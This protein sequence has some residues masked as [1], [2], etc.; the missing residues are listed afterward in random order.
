[1]SDE[2]LKVACPTCDT[3]LFFPKS[4]A[5]KKVNCSSCESQLTVPL[6][7]GDYILQQ[8]KA[9]DEFSETY[10]AVNKL[11]EGRLCRLRVFNDLVT[12]DESLLTQLKEK[13]KTL[14]DL[15]LSSLV[16]IYGY[17]QHQGKF[18]I[19]SA[20]LGKSLKGRMNREK[21][22]RVQSYNYSLKIAESLSELFT[23]NLTHGNLKSSTINLD[24][25]SNLWL[26]D[27]A[28]SWFVASEV[29][30][31]QEGLNPINNMFYAAPELILNRE[32]TQESDIYALGVLF[33]EIFTKQK[34]FNGT[35][36]EVL[37]D[38]KN[39]QPKSMMEKASSIPVELDRLVL[40]MLD[41]AAEK[42]PSIDQVIAEI[43]NCRDNVE[44]EQGETILN[45]FSPKGDET[46]VT[47][48]S[49]ELKMDLLHST[50]D[51]HLGNTSD[52]VHEAR[53][54][55]AGELVVED[56]RESSPINIRKFIVVFLVLV[57]L[58]LSI[59]IILRLK[60][61]N[62]D[63]SSQRKVISAVNLIV[64]R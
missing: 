23:N 63:N 10:L 35:L 31:K 51:V 21:L 43:K 24:K 16:E 8:C 57:V 33:Y 55:E 36:N 20:P 62:S 46:V 38:H 41:K 19:E 40:S 34:P 14:H 18:Y 15:K 54:E 6:E 47:M 11:A 22:T 42:R 61:K 32:V 49:P 25:E 53:A 39:L 26:Y 56:V 12:L 59:A 28:I 9:N 52:E 50:S 7:Q 1:M 4:K 17:G 44:R 13:V 48:K 3:R 64:G 58:G 27:S 30:K 29:A 60:E 45:E 37:E 2:Q 5:L